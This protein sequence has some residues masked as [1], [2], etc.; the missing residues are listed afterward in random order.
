MAHMTLESTDIVI[1]GGG[2]AGGTLACALAQGGLNVTLID[3]STRQE[4]GEIA[5][6]GRA[7]AITEGSVKFLSSLGIWEKA[8]KFAAP[9]REIRVSDQGSHAYVHYDHKEVGAEALGYIIQSPYMNQAIHQVAHTLPTLKWID[10]T[11][12]TDLQFS[13]TQVRSTLD[14]GTQNFSSPLVIIA[15]GRQSSWRKKLS[16][17]ATQWSYRQTALV[18]TIEHEEPHLDT[19]FEHFR[20]NGPFALLPTPH[21]CQSSIV[22]S[23][24]DKNIATIVS[25]MNDNDHC[26][27]SMIM[28]TTITTTTRTIFMSHVCTFS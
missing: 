17:K 25:C 12:V 9:I 2:P 10:Q 13:E 27:N 18:C 4:K 21:P 6:D 14:K 15:D 3:K 16:Q 26:L 11:K 24:K 20:P 7:W 8:Q 23:E 1:I 19:A 22:W 28:A 5:S